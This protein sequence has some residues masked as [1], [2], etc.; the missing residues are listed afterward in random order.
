MEIAYNQFRADK[1]E[2]K[3]AKFKSEMD[4]DDLSV[5]AL[6]RSKAQIEA[7]IE[8]LKRQ[9]MP[10][11]ESLQ[12]K[13]KEIDR[14]KMEILSKK[15]KKQSKFEAKDNKVKLYVNHRDAITNRLIGRY[16]E[17][18]YPMEKELEGLQACK[19]RAD[20]EVAMMNAEHEAS[21][22]EMQEI[23][24]QKAQL[25]EAYRSIG[26]SDKKIK[27]DVAIKILAE[28]LAQNRKRIGMENEVMAKRQDVIDRKIAKVDAKANPYR[29]KRE[30]FARVKAGRPVDMKVKTRERSQVFAGEET[31]IGHTRQERRDEPMIGDETVDGSVEAQNE[32]QQQAEPQ[33]PTTSSLNMPPITPSQKNIE[34]TEEETVSTNDPLRAAAWHTIR[35]M[36]DLKMKYSDLNGATE[37]EREE[38]FLELTRRLWNEFTVHGITKNGSMDLIRESD[39]DGES[40]LK[41][42]ELAGFSIDRDKVNFIKSGT[43]RES[44]VIG[45]TSEKQSGVIAEDKGKKLTMDHHG[46]ES[47][48]TTS[49]TKFAYELLTTLNLLK[50]EDYL[51]KFVDFVTACDN[52]EF[53]ADT[54]GTVYK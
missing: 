39:L 51:D 19:R 48:R 44:G 17:K 53:S 54:Y 29:D 36:E 6:D 18:L 32:S 10:G 52:L 3:S 20:L 9:G 15:D 42:L 22:I 45:D 46:P 25:E 50:K 11:T 24:Q 34:T 14:Q 8:T 43:T 4:V 28:Q 1:N 7:T 41:L 23:E 26:Y 31:I 35:K 40:W 47:D 30:D 33:Q 13:L 27:K 49:A 21:L 16:D 38:K 2:K 5:N 12:I 37:K